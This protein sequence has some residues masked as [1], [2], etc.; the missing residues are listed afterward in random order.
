MVFPYGIPGTL[1]TVAVQNV[2]VPIHVNGGAEHNAVAFGNLVDVIHFQLLVRKTA[3][4]NVFKIAGIQRDIA[5]RN[6]SF[7]CNGNGIPTATGV[8]RIPGLV[9]VVQR[10]LMAIVVHVK[11]HAVS[12]KISGVLNLV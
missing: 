4:E 11:I 7:L 6:T 10:S 5:D 9:P 12:G 2:A 1:I 3:A 8:I